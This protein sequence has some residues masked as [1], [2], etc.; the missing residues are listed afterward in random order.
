MRSTLSLIQVLAE[1][2]WRFCCD[3][4]ARS[5]DPDETRRVMPEVGFGIRLSQSRRPV[6][7]AFSRSRREL[8]SDSGVTQSMPEVMMTGV[9]PTRRFADRVEIFVGQRDAAVAR[10]RRAAVGVA[11]RTVQPDAVALAASRRSSSFG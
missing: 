3:Q 8:S 6:F 4:A 5:W 11:W 7:D 1:L 9:T 10:A 2:T